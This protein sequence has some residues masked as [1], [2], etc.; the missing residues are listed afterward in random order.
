M[1]P[2]ER[3]TTITPLPVEVTFIALMATA[4]A[5]NIGGIIAQLE[6]AY[7][8]ASI[9]LIG[10]RGREKELTA[11]FP[12]VKVVA[13]LPSGMLTFRRF[14]HI[15]WRVARRI[16]AD[17]IGVAYGA[18]GGQGYACL[19]WAG[20]LMGG[21]RL[22]GLYLHDHIYYQNVHFCRLYA[23]R[24]LGVM[25]LRLLY[26]VE[27]FFRTAAHLLTLGRFIDDPIDKRRSG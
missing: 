23:G 24:L 8:G 14:G 25:L 16:R 20:L 7:P 26:P 11:A 27:V 9:T 10:Q 19:E 5:S 1:E 21:K 6:V 15:D 22:V 4:P 17:I 13:A 2:L 3:L 18:P 12:G